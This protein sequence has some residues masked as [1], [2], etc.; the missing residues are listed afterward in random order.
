MTRTEIKLWEAMQDDSQLTGRFKPQ[1]WV[2]NGTRRVDFLEPALRLV[3][4]ADDY[5]TH[6]TQGG[7]E[8]G[9]NRDAALVFE[10]GFWVRHFSYFQIHNNLE[11]VIDQIRWTCRKLE[12]TMI[13]MRRPTKAKP[14]RQAERLFE[15]A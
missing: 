10:G 7:M 14:G 5:G 4:E 6:G 9:Y 3:I 15:V 1:K 12:A 11:W 8:E 2:L 13:A